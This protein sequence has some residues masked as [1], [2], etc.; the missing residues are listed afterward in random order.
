MAYPIKLLFCSKSGVQR[1]EL[2]VPAFRK[3]ASICTATIDDLHHGTILLCASGSKLH[4]YGSELRP[5]D[6]IWQKVSDA[7]AFNMVLT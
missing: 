5:L 7:Q 4:A 2:Q 1:H 6:L 3:H